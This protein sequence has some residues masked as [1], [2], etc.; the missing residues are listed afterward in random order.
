V[1]MLSVRQDV[2]RGPLRRFSVSCIRETTQPEGRVPSVLDGERACR[3]W[4]AEAALGAL[5]AHLQ[6][7]VS[8]RER[9]RLTR[10]SSVVVCAGNG[11]L[12]WVRGL[13]CSREFPNFP[14]VKSQFTRL[15]R[16]VVY[17]VKMAATRCSSCAYA[18][19]CATVGIEK[20]FA[21][22]HVWVCG[23][24]G[25]WKGTGG[26]EVPVP[27]CDPLARKY[28]K[29]GMI[30]TECFDGFQMQKLQT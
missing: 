14:L 11:S 13:K 25:K 28:A 10:I 21:E 29:R 12:L 9:K 19:L 16:V 15:P 8:S 7:S 1:G 27:K 4:D 26:K 30:C 22:Q 5:S 17:G 24:C 20:A 18:A 6:V 2:Y 3:P 23:M